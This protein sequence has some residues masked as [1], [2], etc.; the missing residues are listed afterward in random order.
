MNG[1]Q[2]MPHAKKTGVGENNRIAALINNGAPA[3]SFVAS[4]AGATSAQ[5]HTSRPLAIL[6]NV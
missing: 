2:P 5:A 3:T 1:R 4:V 6:R